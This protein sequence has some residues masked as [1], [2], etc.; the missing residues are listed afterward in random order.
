MQEAKQNNNLPS[1]V[2]GSA[3]H[4]L[5]HANP[6][7]QT[8]SIALS[9]TNHSND[10]ALYTS[11]PLPLTNTPSGTPTG[12]D[13][14]ANAAGPEG[15]FFRLPIPKRPSPPATPAANPPSTPM[16]PAKNER[17][18]GYYRCKILH[19]RLYKQIKPIW[20]RLTTEER[21]LK[22]MHYFDLQLN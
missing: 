14:T 12:R 16:E 1:V 9:Q 20:N 7:S 11:R 5:N 3:A 18:D 17:R 2:G 4:P 19:K 13:V 8:A 6:P 10:N 21:L 22:C 15:R